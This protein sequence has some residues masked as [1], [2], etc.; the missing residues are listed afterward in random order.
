MLFNALN[1]EGRGKVLALQVRSQ[2][3]F[4]S[5]TNVP[6]FLVAITHCV[7]LT[8]ACALNHLVLVAITH[9]LLLDKLK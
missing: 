5:I 4:G 9:R 8:K 6:P 2:I 3:K 1:M 7:L